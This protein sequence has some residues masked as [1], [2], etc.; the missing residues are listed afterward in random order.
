MII[1]FKE[2]KNHRAAVA[3]VD[4][5]FD[6]LHAGHVEY[7]NRASRLG[8]PLLCNVASDHYLDRKHYPVL[9]QGER[10][11]VIDALRP[12]EY[13]H[14]SEFDTEGV[15]R[16]L[17][18]RYY[19]KGD[20]WKGRLPEDQV[21]ICEE[22][23]IEIVYLDTVI[24][25]SSEI[26]RRFLAHHGVESSLE[27]YETFVLNQEEPGSR[28]FSADYFT[29]TWRAEG[30]AYTVET[31]RK[32]EG[33]NPELIKEVFAPKRVIDM[34]CGPG[35]LMFLLW[36]TGVTADGVDFSP[37]SKQIAP[38]EVADR[39]RM[40]SIADIDLPD[41]SYDLVICRE[42]FEHMPVISVQKAV[43]NLT[44]ISS[45]FVYVTTRFH[46]S[47]TSLFDVST[48]F[49]V[50]PTHITCMNKDM[51]RLMFLLQG[52][53]RRADLEARMDWLNKNRVLVYEKFRPQS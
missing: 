27:R 32:M 52:F 42:V 16:E 53:R 8:L 23:N 45:R 51:L 47:P 46:P 34:G 39:I 17:R 13:V 12:I 10:A 48:E 30:N 5:A 19:V 6:P 20:D 14:A 49:D 4:G 11:Q 41:D 22:H 38:P 40:G 43:Q 50:D 21:A 9:P 2:L 15:L 31:R 25:S 44:R 35:A 7:F 29:A 28:E 36:E 3:M 37:V 33:R 24:N 18:P 1:P 26:L